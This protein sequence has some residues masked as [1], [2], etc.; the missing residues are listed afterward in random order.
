MTNNK[1]ESEM[2]RE[3][4][5]ERE[6]GR[7]MGRGRGRERERERERGKGVWSLTASQLQLSS[8][9]FATGYV[10]SSLALASF[11]S[12]AVLMR[13][14]EDSEPAAEFATY[15]VVSFSFGYR[16]CGGMH[17]RKHAVGGF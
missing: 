1:R 5:W 6:R 16:A 14:T 7:G 15:P 2:E 13:T 8:V 9:C 12:V 11:T 3:R 4:E 17:A 10:V